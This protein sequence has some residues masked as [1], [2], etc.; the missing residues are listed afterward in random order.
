V[1]QQN[2][3]NFQPASHKED[4]MQ[5][6]STLPTARFAAPLAGLFAVLFSFS[7]QAQE[8]QPAAAPPQEP[9][10]QWMQGPVEG[11][12]DQWATLKV[13]EGTQFTGKA[14]TQAMM[15]FYG[16][17]LTNKEVGML[18]PDAGNW[19][20]V[21]D[22]DESGYVKDDDADDLDADA[23]LKSII[24]GNEAANETRR[25]NNWSTLTIEGWAVPPRYDPK[26]K[27][28]E[29][30][31]KGNSEGQP[32][33][34]YNMRILGRRGVMEANLVCSP[35]D[36]DTVLPQFQAMLDGYAFKP[37]QTYAEYTKGDKLAKYGLAALI[38]GGGLAVAAKTGLLAG[39]FKLIAKGGKLIVVGVI[40]VGAGIASV[41]KKLFK[42]D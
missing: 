10:I 22:F 40:A 27:N 36:F 38:A 30:A 4:P 39:L 14:G 41:F 24:D 23:L 26:T 11:A 13:P 15:Q 37:G 28:L 2:P 7:A 25:Q 21:F 29:W 42:R 32:V 20:V 6:F 33:L 12:I 9:A 3:V 18:R 34:N 31:T 17:P 1:E 19:F 8:G 16:N 5:H 35:K